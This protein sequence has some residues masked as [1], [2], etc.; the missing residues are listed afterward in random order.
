MEKWPTAKHFTSWLGLAPQ[1]KVSGGRVLSSRIRPGASRAA[2]AFCMAALIASRSSTALGAFSRRLAVRRG[3][4][5]A[6]A[7]TARKLAEIFYRSIRYGK[8]YADPGA[9]TYEEEQKDR[10]IARLTRKARLLG[11]DLVDK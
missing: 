2:S 9:N 3:K 5:K 4:Q 6:H 7:A 10:E 11:F 1:N 8:S